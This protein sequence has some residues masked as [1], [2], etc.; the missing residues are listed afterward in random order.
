MG[1]GD[2]QPNLPDPTLKHIHTPYIPNVGKSRIEGDVPCNILEVSGLECC[3]G[4]LDRLDDG[5]VFLIG[6]I[7]PHVLQRGSECRL[8]IIFYRKST[9]SSS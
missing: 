5:V 3:L 8:F 9:D 7:V 2:A 4:L 1:V 6:N